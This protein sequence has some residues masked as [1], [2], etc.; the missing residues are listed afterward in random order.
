MRLSEGQFLNFLKD[1]A[2]SLARFWAYPFWLLCNKCHSGASEIKSGRRNSE[3]KKCAETLGTPQQNKKFETLAGGWDFLNSGGG[4]VWLLL[5]GFI[6]AIL[7][8]TWHEWVKY[9][10]TL[11]ETAKKTSSLTRGQVVISGLEF[12]V[13]LDILQA[14][15]DMQSFCLHA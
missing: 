13:L 12:L 7:T 3:I 5:M 14:L 9:R 8:F 1:F 4:V 2:E 15:L 10:W 6:S 11:F